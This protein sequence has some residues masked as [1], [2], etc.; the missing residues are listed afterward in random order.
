MHDIL[1]FKDTVINAA[2]SMILCHYSFNVCKTKRILL[3]T[4]FHQISFVFKTILLQSAVKIKGF[5]MKAL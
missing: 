5:A 1:Y 2:F 3:S 4:P